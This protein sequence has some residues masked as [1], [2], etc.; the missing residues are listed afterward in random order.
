MI[1]AGL[2]RTGTLSLQHA[3]QRLLDGRCY[4]MLEVVDRV[5]H[6]RVW[7]AALEGETPDWND[8]LDG[9]TAAVD[10][11]ASAFWQELSLA[12]PEAKVLLSTRESP[13]AWWESASPTV[14]EVARRDDIP[15]RYAAWQAM[16][17]ILLRTKLTADVDDEE[18]AIRGYERHNEAVRATVEPGRLIEWRPGD[19]W[20]PICAG[21]GLPVPDEP[22]PHLNRRADWPALLARYGA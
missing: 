16:F 22:F 5:D 4:H 3:L 18:S 8:A 9:Y 2:P 19:G 14:L 13:E 21:L 17:R 6:V 11:P 1:G 15:S 20:E 10:W 7:Q 12:N